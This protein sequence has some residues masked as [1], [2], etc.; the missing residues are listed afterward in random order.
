[1]DTEDKYIVTEFMPRGSLYDN[2]HPQDHIHSKFDMKTVLRISCDV[3]Q[4]MAYLHGIPVLHRDLT[5]SNIL[6][7]YQ[8]NAKVAGK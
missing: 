5:S 4:G 3:A 1:M 6:L 7:D 2:L 8:M